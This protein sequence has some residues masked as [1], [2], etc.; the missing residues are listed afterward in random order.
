MRQDIIIGASGMVGAHLV[1]TLTSNER[2]SIATYYSTPIPSAIPLDIRN[3][4]EVVRLFSEIEPDC[5]YLPAALP[6]VDYCESHPAET[7]QTNVMGA[8]QVVQAANQVGA[9]V[10]YFSTDFIF[11]G[12]H[13]PYDEADTAN[14]V[15][16][17]GRQKLEAEHFVGLFAENFLIIRT[18]VVYGWE[19]QGKNFVFRLIRSLQNGNSV[20][21]PVDQI[22]SP[23][24]VNNLAQI[25]VELA[26]SSRQG[27]INVTG[28]DYLSRYDF[29]LYAADVFSLDKSLILPV[30][31]AELKQPA[32]R[33]L[34]AGLRIDRVSAIS[35]TPVIGYRK[36]LKLMLQE[37]TRQISSSD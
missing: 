9:R 10:I 14:P 34:Q 25:A 32:R 19:K 21:A 27:V 24:Y 20:K 28:P 6:N 18:T 36:G 5:V 12:E 30:T 26:S 2:Q 33:P 35:K 8:K 17:Y 37:Q 11:D 23:T 31:T 22:G 13:G 3:R 16:E 7:Y 15:S 29:A 1:A 4:A